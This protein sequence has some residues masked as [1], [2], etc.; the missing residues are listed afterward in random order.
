MKRC[1]ISVVIL[2]IIIFS[3]FTSVCYIKK[4]TDV[5]IKEINQINS[6]IQDNDSSSALVQTKRLQKIWE[7]KKDILGI[8]INN[9]NIDDV[10]FALSKL[11]P[12][13]EH[14]DKSEFCSNLNYT[15][16]LISNIYENDCVCLSN[17]T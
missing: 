3:A 13:L 4:S 5:L 15:K 8:F 7:E 6:K 16:S 2:A 10:T 12:L 1:V 17:I 11:V 9:D 14:K